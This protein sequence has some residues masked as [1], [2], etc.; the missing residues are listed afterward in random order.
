[1]EFKTKLPFTKTERQ[2]IRRD[3]RRIDSR[4]KLM[5]NNYI[6]YVEPKC[7]SIDYSE[8]GNIPDKVKAQKEVKALLKNLRDNF[9]C[10]PY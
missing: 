3:L 4:I 2:D 6:G 5:V 10:N 1:M 7:C 8:I 9:C